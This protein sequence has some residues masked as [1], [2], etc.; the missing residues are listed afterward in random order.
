MIRSLAKTSIKNTIKLLKKATKIEEKINAPTGLTN[1]RLNAVFGTRGLA[2]M[3]LYRRFEMIS[4][5][6]NMGLYEM[7]DGRRGYMIQITP[8]PYLGDRTENI[9]KNL[10]AALAKEGFVMN[11]TTYAS[12][13]IK[14][15]IDRWEYLH[16]ASPKIDNPLILK[17]WVQGRS[18]AYRKWS[19]KS[20]M[21]F[22]DV[23]L[24]NFI[25]V[26]S[27]LT[28]YGSND[29]QI[30]DSYRKAF[31]GLQKFGPACFFPEDLLRMTNEIFKPNKE[32]WEPEY[33]SSI[34][35]NNQIGLNTKINVTEKSR[36]NGSFVIDDT[37]HVQ[38][39]TTARMPRYLSMF[40]YQQLFYDVFGEEID[41]PLPSSYMVSMTIS[42]KDLEDVAQS[43]VDKAVNDQDQL[44]RIGIKDASK[45]PHFGDRYNE[46]VETVAAVKERGERL[47]KTMFQIF[48][49][50]EDEG[51]LDRQTKALMERF[52]LSNSG[53][54]ILEPERHPVVALNTFLFS[55]PLMHLDFMQ[56]THLKHRFFHRWTSNNASTAPIVSDAKGS[57]DFIN[58][59]EGRTGQLIR[60]DPKTE[61]NQNIII[62]GP[63]GTGKS[64]LI[65]ELIMSS[66]SQGVKC[67]A[68]DLGRSS[69]AICKNIGGKHI[70]F[71]ADSNI[72]MNFFTNII[73]RNAEY[74]DEE[75]GGQIVN[76][77][78]IDPEEYS[79]IIPMIGLMCKQDLKSSFGDYADDNALRQEMSIYIQRAVEMSHRRRGR[80]AGMREV[81]EN[82]KEIR[83]RYVKTKGLD[84]ENIN[85]LI[86]GLHNYGSPNGMY[87]KYFNGANNID[88]ADYDLAVFEFENLRNMGDLL[89]VA[90]AG[91]MQ[92]IAT[93][94]FYNRDTPKLF[95]I[96][97]V[98]IMAL[99]NPIMVS[100][101]E[102]FSLRLRKYGVI[103]IQATQAS[104]HYQTAHPKAKEMYN[105]AAWKIFLKRD[106]ASIE[107]DIRSGAISIG[108]FEK[109][110][111]TSL[112][113][114][115]PDFAEFY[116]MGVKNTM[117][118]RLKVEPLSNLLYT[119]NPQDYQRIRNASV[120]TGLSKIGAIYYLSKIDD[121]VEEKEALNMAKT[122]EER[123]EKTKT[124]SD[125]GE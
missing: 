62:I 109:R 3:L 63:M 124:I 58:I 25:T 6:D 76:G 66:V 8:P 39:L 81:L 47:Y 70:E 42:A 9:F 28:P 31:A 43:K 50:E 117:V 1:K 53:G 112:Q 64:Y 105:L 110:V 106:E 21:R 7:A 88:I 23:R 121:G 113:F 71:D 86:S 15:E 18:A 38:T 60:L 16:S 92:K 68:F 10:I 34:P 65:N 118:C 85:M 48:V 111:M 37:M 90:Q 22:V 69:E 87:F 52:K 35:L 36:K 45:N 55:F 44:R 74:V 104:S 2:D 119:T 12:K 103:F 59:F 120:N 33:D 54:W 4:E 83:D 77:K 73:E 72:C 115:P 125:N 96:D 82:L 75:N 101:L 57:G 13:N 5:R 97:E 95:S 98:K 29:E 61:S 114:N 100:Y 99:D 24:R 17:E 80:S 93:E 41:I 30:I 20:M 84:P 26:I 108:P 107:N 32:S 51:R 40:A 79:T 94:L 67:R 27:V 56:D 78:I 89:Y 11:I 14:H 116:V 122:Y 102:D 46:S 91:I 123:V 19:K 49:F